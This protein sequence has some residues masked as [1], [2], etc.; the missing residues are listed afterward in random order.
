VSL[1]GLLNLEHPKA[2]AADIKEAEQ[3]I[4]IFVYSL[5]HPKYGTFIVDS[6]VSTRVGNAKNNPDISYLIEKVMKFRSMQVR[7]TTKQLA[8]QLGGIDGVLLT[9]IHMDHILGLSDL[10]ANVPVYTGP[11]EASARHLTHLATRGTTNRLLSSAGTL[12]EWQFD[13]EGVIDVFGDGS[14]WAIQS[15]GHTPGSTAYIARTTDGAHLMIGDAT[16]TRWGWD[17]GVEPGTY[18]EDPATSVV[19]LKKLLDLA[20]LHPDMVV[21]PGHQD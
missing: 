14:L 20:G 11:G 3:D 9:H 6:G 8:A 4:Q 10:D 2:V 12:R 18:S 19:S 16:H 13:S 21:H 15:P 17:N 7:L 1:S 5:E